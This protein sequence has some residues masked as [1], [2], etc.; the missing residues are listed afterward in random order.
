[1]LT[2]RE[3]MARKRKQKAQGK[4]SD[5][6][7]VRIDEARVQQAEARTVA[8]HTVATTPQKVGV[9]LLAKKILLKRRASTE[10]AQSPSNIIG[11]PNTGLHA[12]PNLPPIPEL[13]PL[14]DE[15]LNDEGHIEVAV[16]VHIDAHTLGKNDITY[17]MF[18]KEQRE[19]VERAGNGESFCLI[20]SA[21]TGKTTAQKGVVSELVER[22]L[23]SN[24]TMGTDRVLNEGS[25]AIAVVSFTNKAVS[26]IKAAL[27]EQFK[28]HC[29]TIHKLLE[30]KP[31]EYDEEIID[32]YG[33][34]TGEFITKRRF[35]PTYGTDDN[36]VGDNMILPHL[37][38]VII[39][40]AGS[41]P[42]NLFDILIRALPCSEETRFIYLGDLNQLPPVFGDAVL[43]FKLL[44]LPIVELTEVYRAALKSPITKL[45]VRIKTGKGISDKELAEIAG[46]YGDDG[47]LNV[48]P[49]SL[50]GN[51]CDSE[52]MCHN[53]GKHLYDMTI[54]G[55][56]LPAEDVVL[57]PFNKSFGTIELN[58]HIGQ[59]RR[60]MYDLT[61]YHII[62]GREQHFYTTGTKVLYD[63]QECI[64]QSIEINDKYMGEPTLVASKD[65]DHWG[66]NRGTT[67]LKKE[68]KTFDEM[69]DMLDSVHIVNT[70]E[71]VNQC[72]HVLELKSLE[73]DDMIHTINT[74]AQVNGMLPISVMTV[75]KAQ[76]SEWRRVIVVAHRTHAQMVNREILYTATTRAR[77]QLDIY[78]SGEDPRKINGSMFQKG[79]IKSVFKGVTLNE[80]LDYFRDK[81]RREAL[82]AKLL[83]KRTAREQLQLSAG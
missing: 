36:G 52:Q 54:K 68:Y 25:P 69:S 77:H 75:H 74:A 19:A 13:P 46:D 6:T 47:V 62:A 34:E 37:D 72:S 21:G 26:N 20:G 53:F 17:D 55:E 16:T 23:I 51:K 29:T 14:P 44:D 35:I 43:G 32:S 82:E 71:K 3:R 33:S 50:A 57:I 81:R 27:E 4:L 45:A 83:A 61:T 76:G 59:A 38:I 64:I 1:M 2:L 63:K 15:L 12:V 30:Y 73:Y 28:P 70:D 41:V 31:D 49:F 60:D 79:V 67:I 8:Q 48:K 5:T 80:K 9:G 18:N 11:L 22:G 66:L 10:I 58:K 39:E 78:Y 42:T 40:E 24:L 65:L 7:Q 56:F